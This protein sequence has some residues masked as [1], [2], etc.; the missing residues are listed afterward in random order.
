VYVVGSGRSGTTLMDT[1]LGNHPRLYGAGELATLAVDNVFHRIY[2]PCGKLTDECE[3]WGAVVGEWF[4]R[5][6]LRNLEE[7]GRLRQ[8]FEGAR[9]HGL[10]RLLREKLFRSRAFNEYA[11]Q[12]TE[13]YRAVRKISGREMIV[14]SSA[15]PMRALSLS[16]M[17][18]IDLRLIHLV[19]D[20]RGVAWSLKKG[21]REDQ[22]AG[23]ATNIEP[24]P[25]WRSA[26][27]WIAYNVVSSWACRWVPKGRA[28]FCRYEDL[29]ANSGPVLRG[30]GEFLGCD[31]GEVIQR[32]D[33][34]E[35][36]KVGCTFG[37]NRLRMG[38]NVRLRLDTEWTKNLSPA[39][40]RTLSRM[41]GW[42]MRKYGY[43]V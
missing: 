4:E 12:T 29:S 11:R 8:K 18:G 23:L 2:C 38:G 7:H 5:T 36:L 35:G 24:R 28:H 22:K 10:S 17:P 6:G 14:D 27:T 15:I 1:I 31:F 32:I 9:L 40:T 21:F 42:L 20:G 25:V 33:S 37:G 26:L 39:E 41:C 19:R 16:M 3:F 34:G 13:L 43:Q 30:L